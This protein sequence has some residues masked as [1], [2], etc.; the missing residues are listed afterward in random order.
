MELKNY[1][2][3]NAAGDVLPGAQAYLY[4]PGTTTLAEG[5][6]GV[7]GNPIA[8][9]VTAEVN[10]LLQFRAPNGEYDMRVTAPGREYTARIQCMDVTDS[11]TDAQA[12]A[13]SAAASRIVAEDAAELAGLVKIYATHADARADIWNIPAG[14]V[15]RVLADETRSGRSAWYRSNTPTGES[16]GLDFVNGSYGVNDPLTFIKSDDLRLVA[17]PASATANGQLGEFAVDAT[18]LYVAVGTNAWRRAALS[19]F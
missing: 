9:P 16:L 10:G 7:F 15:V 6:Q 11:L 4:Q 19:T 14:Q 18:H 17:V 12:A 13:D 8:N 3:Q 1:F 2:A 5:L